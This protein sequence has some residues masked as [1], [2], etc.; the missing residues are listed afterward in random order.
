MSARLV[1]YSTMLAAL[2][3]VAL[4]STAQ[5]QSAAE[6][7]AQLNEE[8]KVLW[9]KKKDPKRAAEKFRQATTLNPEPQYYFNLCY[10]L[11]QLAR[12]KEARTACRAVASNGGDEKLT[13]K[14]QV[15]LDDIAQR[16]PD[17]PEQDV[18]DAGTGDSGTG[19]GTG[20]T[21]TGTGDTG[22]GTGDTGTGTGDTG[23]GT[24]DTGTGTGDTGTGDT[25]TDTSGTGTGDTGT[26]TETDVGMVG[27]QTVNG[28]PPSP[29]PGLYQ[30]A[31]NPD[32]YKWAVGA[33]LGFMGTNLADGYFGNGGPSFK[34]FIDFAGLRSL[35]AGL[36]LYINYASLSGGDGSPANLWDLGG[37]LFKHVRVTMGPRRSFYLTPLI[38]AHF[39]VLQSADFQSEA[40]SALGIRGEG[41]ATW[42]F[43]AVRR[44]AVRAGLA[45]SYYL[46]FADE[47]GD[48]EAYGLDRGS[49]SFSVIVGYSLRFTTPFGR[50]S[51]ITLE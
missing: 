18:G 12:F 35:R 30:P 34:G 41:T 37:A 32:D 22:T 6:K 17:E 50:A 9:L 26:G 7:A 15:V 42:L 4:V 40:L 3:M 8:G 47:F 39:G 28:Q 16:I 38:G 5:A 31:K 2:L 10:A 13:E 43:G 11:H 24:G 46:P 14:A 49:A 36:Q 44:H 27:D 45:L 23:T 1:C 48:A 51:L 25:G 29:V 19:T 20:D 21:G 33:D